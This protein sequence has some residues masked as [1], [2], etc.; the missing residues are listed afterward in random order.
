MRN[1][2]HPNF[3]YLEIGTNLSFLGLNKISV[4]ASATHGS[5]WDK[6]AFLGLE[7]EGANH[8]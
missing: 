8:K 6:S 3:I 2:W 4:V 5:N 7:T 1:T